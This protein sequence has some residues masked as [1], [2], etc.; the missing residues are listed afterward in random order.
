MTQLAE[1]IDHTLLKPEATHEQIEKLVEEAITYRFKSV[2]IH[3]YWVPYCSTLLQG[4][5]PKVCTVIG[6]PLGASSSRVKA[7][8]TKQAIVDG[9]TEIDM[10]MNIGELKAGRE[11]F[12]KNDIDMVVEAAKGKAIVK[13]IIETAL[14]TDD[15]KI[16][17][18]H[19]VESSGADFIKT[20]TGFAG[21]GATV[22]DVKLLANTIEGSLKIK[23]S[24]GIRNRAIAE[25]I[26]AAGADRLGA[27]SGVQIL[28]NETGDT[29]Y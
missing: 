20:S 26:I 4:K 18:C 13:V 11:E 12:V 6:F 9:A 2:C 21:G 29:S 8:E 27:S 24:G 1:Y 3:P 16:K 17:A 23:A 19:I 28:E 5:T 14:L 7:F 25:E 15:E 10:V 22:K